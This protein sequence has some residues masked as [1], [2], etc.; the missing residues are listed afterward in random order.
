MRRFLRSTSPLLFC[1]ALATFAISSRAQVPVVEIGPN[2]FQNT[3]NTIQNLTT[4]LTTLEDLENQ[5]KRLANQGQILER[6][7]R[8]GTPRSSA[9]WGELGHRLKTLATLVD[10]GEAL[11]YETAN[12]DPVFRTRFPGGVAPDD[13]RQAVETLS[14]SLLDTL[15]GVLRSSGAN[16]ADAESVQR[17][18]DQL[19]IDNTTAIGQLAAVQTSNRL[20]SL[21]VSELAKLRQLLAAQTN[22]ITVYYA[23]VHQ[24]GVAADA[25]L[26]RFVDAPGS[27]RS[28]EGRFLTTPPLCPRPPCR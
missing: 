2:V 7:R 28:Y 15:S 12:L 27:I 16:V 23:T 21:E 19:Q 20:Q 4:M 13:W 5:T 24:Q 22:A 9:E 26:D 3:L 14:E 6:L 18:L 11:T 10:Q 25:A 8:D 17:S 1:I